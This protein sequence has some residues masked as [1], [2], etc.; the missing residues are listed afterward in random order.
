MASKEKPKK[1]W[2]Q[3]TWLIIVSLIFLA[4]LGIFL[5]WKYA[6]WSKTWKII[7][8]IAASLFMIYA[9]VAG[10]NAPPTLSIDNV[11]N[12]RVETED[13]SYTV[14][15]KIS[16]GDRDAEI[17]VNDMPVA[18]DKEKFTAVV[19]L[20]E[21][22]NQVKVIAVKKDHRIERTFVVYRFTAAEIQARKDAEAKKL[23]EEE[24]KET[25]RKAEEESKAAAKKAEEDKKNAE[26][27]ARSK[28]EADKRAAEEA[29]KN[30]PKKSFGDGTF[31][32]NKDIEPGTYRTDGGSSC[33]YERL[34]GTSGSFDD[35]IAND[36][37][38]GQT[39]VTIVP[40]DVA[41]KSQRCGTWNKI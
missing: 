30:A 29:A 17:T 7:I 21:G 32:V 3:A 14:S 31:L 39:V 33:Y 22:D 20:K 26:A 5:M 4:P 34:S 12:N 24:A 19:E 27:A 36:N 41:F 16:Y 35:I 13:S 38:R 28:A 8:T 11:K 18:K 9:V 10:A 23:A 2:Y 15:G 25:A 40:S 37:P 6:S 1:K